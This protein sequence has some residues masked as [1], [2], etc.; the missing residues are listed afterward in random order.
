MIGPEP[1][2][3]EEK[4]RFELEYYEHE[5]QE[6]ESVAKDFFH[7]K[8]KKKRRSVIAQIA[9]VDYLEYMKNDMKLNLTEEEYEYARREAFERL[10][11]EMMKNYF[12]KKEELESKEM[13]EYFVSKGFADL[14]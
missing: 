4:K 8:G 5:K 11:E 3:E 6:A 10:K 2:T 13:R 12:V 1:E 14:L 7:L 9:C